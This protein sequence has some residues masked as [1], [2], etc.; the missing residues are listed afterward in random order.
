MTWPDDDPVPL[1]D[2]VGILIC[3]AG[4]VVLGVVLGINRI[5]GGVSWLLRFKPYTRG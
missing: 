3:L 1:R 4:L 2:W 5:F